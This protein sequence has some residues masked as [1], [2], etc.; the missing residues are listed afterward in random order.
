MQITEE[1]C[2]L[3]AL[4][5]H[6]NRYLRQLAQKI[7][8]PWFQGD[9]IE[10]VQGSFI[11]QGLNPH[12][13]TH[14]LAKIV[15]HF[16]FAHHYAQSSYLFWG[17]LG[18]SISKPPRSILPSASQKKTISKCSMGW[19]YV[20]TTKM[21]EMNVEKWQKAQGQY[22]HPNWA[23]GASGNMIVLDFFWTF[24]TQ[25]T[26]VNKWKVIFCPKNYRCL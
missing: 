9:K 22:S 6:P 11:Y 17:V 25:N 10:F 19:E 23:H 26:M 12:G 13:F 14:L 21:A 5:T 3:M 15:I 2:Y 8:H 7:F 16:S 1:T 18:I 4:L 20:S 24:C